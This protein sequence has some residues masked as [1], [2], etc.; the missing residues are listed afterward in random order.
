MD[1]R[2]YVNCWLERARH[3]MKSFDVHNKRFYSPNELLYWLTPSAP[4]EEASFEFLR[5]W[6]DENVTEDVAS[7]VAREIG[8][9]SELLSIGDDDHAAFIDY[10]ANKYS[11]PFEYGYPDP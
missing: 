7:V 10:V 2:E 1:V 9:I 4:L 3:F 6:C 11:D 5:L 8:A